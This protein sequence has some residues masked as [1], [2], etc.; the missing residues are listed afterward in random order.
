MGFREVSNNGN[1][2]FELTDNSAAFLKALETAAD[3]ALEA[4]GIQVQSDTVRNITASGRVDTGLMRNSIAYAVSGQQPAIGALGGGRKQRTPKASNPSKYTRETPKGKMYSG[5]APDAE[6]S[7]KAVY[8]GSNV[9]YFPYQE[10]GY[11][12]PNGTHV[13]P[14]NALR[15]A[16]TQIQGEIP[17]IVKKAM[18][19]ASEG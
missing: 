13:A 12:L 18:E 19:N 9:S 11:R 5:K 1:V 17:E 3:E 7:Q 2:H 16:C 4:I 8:I 10:L 14:M 6:G 15:N